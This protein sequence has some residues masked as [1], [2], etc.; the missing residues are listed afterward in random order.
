[1]KK[2][3]KTN[4]LHCSCNVGCGLPLQLPGILQTGPTKPCTASNR[5]STVILRALFRST[6][7]TG[8][9]QT[10]IRSIQI[11]SAKLYLHTQQHL[12][13]RD[14]HT[15]GAPHYGRRVIPWEWSPSWSWCLRSGWCWPAPRSWWSS[16]SSAAHHVSLSYLSEQF[17]REIL[18]KRETREKRE[19]WSK[20]K[21]EKTK[22]KWKLKK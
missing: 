20:M 14:Q 18:K 5:T 13:S 6:Y 21:S 2:G 8:A 11:L 19:R 4:Y 17:L 15:T 22:V 3:M 7:K 16:R 12:S 9:R 1:M 10:T